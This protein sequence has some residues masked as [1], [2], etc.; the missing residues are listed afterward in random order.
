MEPL[1]TQKSTQ[2]KKSENLIFNKTVAI[3]EDIAKKV[4]VTYNEINVIVYYVLIPVSWGFMINTTL[5]LV[6]ASILS[7]ILVGIK[8]SNNSF[9]KV[10]D[11]VFY[12]SVSFLVT[13]AKLTSLTYETISVIIC[14][15]LPV[16]VYYILW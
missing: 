14:L 5:G 2:M 4:S 8:L 10:C 3:L 12:I 16:L 7:L 15:I 1:T 6:V 13:I 9:R 11:N